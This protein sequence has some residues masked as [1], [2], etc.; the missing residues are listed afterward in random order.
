MR[1]ATGRSPAAGEVRFRR[2][3]GGCRVQRLQIDRDAA[4][5]ASVV[6]A[7]PRLA[8]RPRVYGSARCEGDR[9]G[10]Q[11][12]ACVCAIDDHVPQNRTRPGFD[13]DVDIDTRLLRVDLR[14]NGRTR[15]QKPRSPETA[16]DLIET[17]GKLRPLIAHA[18]HDTQGFAHLRL[19]KPAGA[20]EVDSP[21][22]VRLAFA[23]HDAH[24][25]RPV[26]DLGLLDVDLR[27]EQALVAIQRVRSTASKDGGIDPGRHACRPHPP[28]RRVVRSRGARCR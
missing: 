22:N 27:R 28:P 7:P 11:R 24:G 18:G 4:I 1:A 25:G 9:F 10:H 14:R 8:E 15:L 17:V 5:Q 3:C 19:G 16:L 21:D 12:L 13:E 26:P 2:C 6:Q 20:L 23:H